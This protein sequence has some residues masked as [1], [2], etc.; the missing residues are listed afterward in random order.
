MRRGVSSK[1][2]PFPLIGSGFYLDLIF[3]FF[4][5]PLLIFVEEEEVGKERKKEKM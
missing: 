3:L 5:S 2:G 4:M 1:K